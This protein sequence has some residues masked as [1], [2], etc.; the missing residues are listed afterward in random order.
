M[1]CYM[2]PLPDYFG[3]FTATCKSNP[4]I[5]FVVINDHISQSY[6]D[7]NITFMKMNLAELN[8]FSSQRLG[9]NI[10][11]QSAWKINELKPLFG[12]I[13][14]EEFKGYDHWGWCDLDI[15]WGNI[16]HFLTDELLNTYNVITTQKL[17]CT[18]HLTLFRNDD[19]GKYLYRDHGNIISLLNDTTYYAFE[20]CCQR[21]HGELFSFDEIRSQG[22]QISMYDIIRNAEKDGKLRAY[23][24]DIIREH[25][26]PINY[27]YKSGKLVDLNNGE[28]FM[29]Y[30]LI[31]VKKIWRYYIPE[32]QKNDCDE[33][34]ITHRGIRCTGDSRLAWETARLRNALRGI[35]K[36]MK[37][38]SAG[39]LIKK[40]F[41]FK[42]TWV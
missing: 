8:A 7:A 19:I 14:E 27:S 35:R 21:W 18:G 30:H 1:T 2:G 20:E 6:T 4:S 13:F 39:S 25:P 24:K 3:Y 26:Q 34:I 33:L 29:Y 9:E 10:Q 22:L 11:L 12:H 42:R 38:Q 17:W 31:T 16:R 5:R 37:S 41:K 32:Y 40:L 36:S 28:E 15:I 23:F